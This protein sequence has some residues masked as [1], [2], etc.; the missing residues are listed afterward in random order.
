MSPEYSFIL[1]LIYWICVTILLEYIYVFTKTGH[2]FSIRKRKNQFLGP[3]PNVS[4]VVA[5]RN[6]KVNLPILFSSLQR[7]SYPGKWECI[8]VDDHSEDGGIVGF[9][10]PTHIRVIKASGEGKKRAIVEGIQAAHFDWIALTDAD[11]RFPDTWLTSMIE[12]AIQ[13]GADFVSGPVVLS[14][15]ERD[16]NFLWIKD[17]FEEMEFRSLITFGA[18]SIYRN[19]P[20]M[21][22]G[23]NLIYKK[24]VFNELGGYSDKIL[25]IASGDDEFWMH[26][27]WK[28]GKKI[29]FCKSVEGMVSTEVTD[30]WKSL[31]LQ[32]I[33]WASKHRHYQSVSVKKS[34]LLIY[35]TH[36]IPW[37][38]L[39][40]GGKWY[41]A[42]FVFGLRFFTDLWFLFRS[43]ELF[44]R[45]WNP[46]VFIVGQI[47]YPFYMSWISI[48]ANT[49]KYIWKNRKVN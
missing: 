7:I 29:S 38:I 37:I 11:C 31:F 14:L 44:N 25:G 30:S 17:A 22:N 10:F 4:I 42:L 15:P 3:W 1:F 46:W 48:R 34:V 6:E 16:R 13:S 9:E 40:S 41:I 26:L 27:L 12:E 39:F 45:T 35:I 8:L 5:F 20:N 28:S 33:R 18:G 32:R 47:F 19:R 49:G 21:C 24:A 2:A 23:A 43:A 36:V